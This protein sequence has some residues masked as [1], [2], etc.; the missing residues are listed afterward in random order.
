[1]HWHQHLASS[2]LWV[3]DLLCDKV[4]GIPS[5][6]GEEGRVQSQSDVPGV[7]R[8]AIKEA[9]EVLGVT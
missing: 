5:R 2:P 3:F 8:R 1:M 4:E 7:L 6:V 9:L